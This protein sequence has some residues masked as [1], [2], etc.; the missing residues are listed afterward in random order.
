[1][2]N[3]IIIINKNNKNKLIKLKYSI[4]LKITL[5]PIMENIDYIFENTLIQTEWPL[6]RY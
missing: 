2:K 3:N 4:I 6:I 5:A 1:M